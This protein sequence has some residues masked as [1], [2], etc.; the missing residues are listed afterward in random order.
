MQFIV[1]SIPE[2]FDAY[3]KY[4]YLAAVI[5][6]RTHYD[7]DFT[8]GFS[9]ASAY[10]AIEGELAICQGYATGFE[11][12]CRKANL[13]CTQVN[14]ISQDISHVWNLVKLESG[15]YHIDVTWADADGVVPLS[16]EWHINF[17]MTQDEILWDREIIDGT[18]ATGTYLLNS[19]E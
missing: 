18:V 2:D 13:W 8:G 16:L 7:N 19:M 11:Y 1:K 15:T 5:S 6:L 3:D 9:T 17:M 10:G 14:G 12:L 4:R